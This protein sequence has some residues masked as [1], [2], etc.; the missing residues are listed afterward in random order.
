MIQQD[1]PDDFQKND[2]NGLI[3]T[4]IKKPFTSYPYYQP[5]VG[6]TS[7]KAIVQ[8]ISSDGGKKTQDKLF[9]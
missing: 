2:I 3:A 6:S 4:A 9:G 7:A 5:S 1:Y 8:I